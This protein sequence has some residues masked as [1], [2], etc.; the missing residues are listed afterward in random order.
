MVLIQSKISDLGDKYLLFD[1][2]HLQRK[3][4]IYRNQPPFSYINYIYVQLYEIE[5]FVLQWMNDRKIM[6]SSFVSLQKDTKEN[7][8]LEKES[9]IFYKFCF[10]IP[11]QYELI[12]FVKNN[13]IIMCCRLTNLMSKIVEFQNCVTFVFW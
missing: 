7:C 5:N 12:L 10:Y 2:V 13:A 1:Y 6:D 11:F 9:A 4:V 3:Y 8:T